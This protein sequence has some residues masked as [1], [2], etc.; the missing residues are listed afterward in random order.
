LL[1]GP[2]SGTSAE[3]IAI[4]VLFPLQESIIFKILA[5]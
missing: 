5:R 1:W 4:S 2:P 3:K